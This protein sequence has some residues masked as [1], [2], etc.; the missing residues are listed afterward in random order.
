[1]ST[2]PRSRWRSRV[3]TPANR[4]V[5]D[6]GR[7]IVAFARKANIPVHLV[8]PPGRPSPEAPDL[9]INNANAYHGQ[10]APIPGVATKNLPNYLG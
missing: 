3:V 10:A 4:L 7:T 1:M 5:C 8:P 6:G 2:A 9:H